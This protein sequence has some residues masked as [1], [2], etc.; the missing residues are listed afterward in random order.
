MTATTRSPPPCGEG[1]GAGCLRSAL[2][3]TPLTQTLSPQGGEVP[4][5]TLQ[6]EGRHANLLPRPGEGVREAGG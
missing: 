6:R 5:L 3:W 2:R 1:L 4:A